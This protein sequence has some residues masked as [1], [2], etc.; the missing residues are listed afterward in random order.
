M[1]VE[2]GGGVTRRLRSFELDA[3]ESG[4]LEDTHAIVDPPPGRVRS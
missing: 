1:G 4:L 2:T 3:T